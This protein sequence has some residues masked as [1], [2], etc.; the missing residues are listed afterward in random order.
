V[1][2]GWAPRGEQLRANP[3]IR[4][5]SERRAPRGA[6]ARGLR[7]DAPMRVYILR[8][9]KESRLHSAF[10]LVLSS[11]HVASCMIEA[12]Q[13]R[14]RF[15]APVRAAD[16]LVQHIYLEGGLIWCSRHDVEAGLDHA[17]SGPTPQE[18]GARP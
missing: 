1:H 18:A 12:P 13:S 14:L 10:D 16:A 17:L 6:L 8:F 4:A 15:L 3:R 5:V 9:D 11:P 2:S 7:R